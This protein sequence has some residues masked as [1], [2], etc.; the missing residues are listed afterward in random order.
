MESKVIQATKNKRN[1]KKSIEVVKLFELQ[2]SHIHIAPSE[3]HGTL[4][5]KNTEKR[6]PHSKSVSNRFDITQ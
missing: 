4:K 6:K 3:L 2:Q 1:V 5:K